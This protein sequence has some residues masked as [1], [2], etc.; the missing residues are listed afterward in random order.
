M[1]GGRRSNG[2]LVPSSSGYLLYRLLTYILPFAVDIAC[3]FWGGEIDGSNII[4]IASSYVRRGAVGS[5]ADQTCGRKWKH[6]NKIIHFIGGRAFTLE[7]PRFPRQMIGGEGWREA[8]HWISR[9][10][11]VRLL[12]V[13]SIDIHTGRNRK[14]SLPFSGDESM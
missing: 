2:Y 14:H 6:I 10:I 9:T 1:V 4:A 8:L 12:T 5:R 11:L 7:E 3:P 13:P